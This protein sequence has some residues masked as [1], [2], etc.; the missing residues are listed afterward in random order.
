MNGL[1][2]YIIIFAGSILVS[3]TKYE[4]R[5]RMDQS[6]IAMTF[7][8]NSV[9]N[10][11]QYL[12][13]LDSFGAKATFYISSYH[14]L[15]PSQKNKLRIMEQHGN[16]IGY[17]TTFH[18]NLPEYLGRHGVDEL[19][20]I[21]I[22]QDLKLMNNEGFY[23]T[24]FA[25]PYGA[26]NYFLDNLLLKKFKSVRALNGTNNLAKSTTRTEH[27][28]I[29]YALGM[30]NTRRSEDFFNKMMEIANQNS[31]C[32]VMVGHEINNRQSRYSVS[33]H[34]L[35]KILQKAKELN[36]RFYR[37]SEISN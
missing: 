5:G 35:K 23:P 21:E 3:C 33:Y 24:V 25:Y 26:H 22:N 10:W 29:L 17:H 28:D 9:D 34:K 14:K 18:S 32:L 13:L 6:G 12:P 30:D 27:N 31:T 15:T 11:F 8:D 2:F 4:H 1:R 7:D 37:I 16:E 19:M 36:L 20:R